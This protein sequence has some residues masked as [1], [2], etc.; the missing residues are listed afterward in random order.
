MKVRGKGCPAP[1]D[2]WDQC[3]LS[4]RLLAALTKHRLEAP[5]AIQKQVPSP[6]YPRSSHDLATM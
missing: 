4:E 6:I 5:F 1:V 3:G 2:T